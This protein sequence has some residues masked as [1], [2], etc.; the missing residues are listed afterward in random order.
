MPR[1]GKSQNPVYWLL[2]DWRRPLKPLFFTLNDRRLGLAEEALE[3]SLACQP[4][5]TSSK[6]VGLGCLSRGLLMPSWH[7][8]ERPV[9]DP[10]EITRGSLGAPTHE[11]LMVCGCP[12]RGLGVGT[13][14]LFKMGP[15]VSSTPKPRFI[16]WQ[17]GCGPWTPLQWNYLEVIYS[18]NS[19]IP[20][21]K[22]YICWSFMLYPLVWRSSLPLWETSVNVQK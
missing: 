11:I 1:R 20:N 8:Q 17:I 13:V 5:W 2:S 3:M 6:V 12:H 22:T 21:Q 18:E 14:D 4:S 9:F 19:Q 16:N 15:N 7:Q 10:S